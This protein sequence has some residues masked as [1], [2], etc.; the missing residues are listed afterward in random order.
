MDR[1]YHL[2]RHGE[3]RQVRALEE[4]TWRDLARFLR[5][6]DI[7]MDA[8]EIR[9]LR[10]DYDI[11][12]A[13]PLQALDTFVGGMF[14][15]ATNPATDWFSYTLDDEDRARYKP[16]AAWL[17]RRTNRIYASL[18][19]SIS[20]FYSEVPGIFANL[21]AFG[22]SFFSQ[23]E[24]V[25]ENFISDR[26]LPVGQCYVSLDI[27]GRING[28][29]RAWMPTGRQVRARWTHAD[30]RD[31]SNYVIIHAVEKNPDFRPGAM[32]Q[33]ERPW[34]S[35]YFSDDVKNLEEYGGFYELPYH[36]L[37]WARRDGKPYATGPGHNARPD[38]GSLNEMERSHLVAGQFAAE[39]PVLMRDDSAF[40]AA[41]IVPNA[42]LEGAFEDGKAHV[43]YL[44]RQQDLK[45]TSAQSEQ[46]REA[47]RQC[48]KFS[49]MQ[50]IMRRPQMTATEFLGFQEEDL[51]LLAPCLVLV[52]G[53]LSD[54]IKRR[55]RILARAGAFADD[56][57]PP[58]MKGMVE[59]EYVSPLAKLQKVAKGNGVLR[60]VQ[61]LG[62]VAQVTQNPG[63]MD[64]VD[65][66]ETANVLHEAF[67]QVPSVLTDP[68]KRDQ[69]RAQRA[70][71][72]QAEMAMQAAERLGGA[73]ADVAHGKQAASLVGQR[74]PGQ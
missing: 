13:T 41:D 9:P 74:G 43:A 5:P 2:M 42:A 11:F 64:N 54:F 16:V 69:I 6:D 3:M 56:P 50:T 10:D 38:M 65:V 72:Q 20:T 39:P 73:Y 31:D 58:D 22:N 71:Q 8:R 33:R 37:Q 1:A 7:A 40:T 30:V 48:L 29:H 27:T 52:Y 67:T 18:G 35:C 24:I 57:P 26:A 44:E 49:L 4:Q 63:A 62:T 53:G 12:D 23:E 34:A 45:L 55:D 70:K 32:D 51:K 14:S 59:I 21:G 66:D 15:Q 47:I 25:G 68:D 46:K 28:V 17:R 60:W 19:P 61:A 36:A